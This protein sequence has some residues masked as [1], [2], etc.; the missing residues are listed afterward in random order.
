ME[1][2]GSFYG[3]FLFFYFVFSKKC[4]NFARKLKLMTMNKNYL[5]MICMAWLLCVTHATDAKSM[6]DFWIS[7]PDS[8]IPTMNANMRTELV[9]LQEMGVKSEVSNL[10]GDNVVLDTLTADFLQVRLSK[11]ATLQIKQ[12][13]LADGKDSLWC[14]VKTFSAPEKDSE[15]QFY[16]QQWQALDTKEY[17]GGKS[18][19]D[20]ME[21]LIQKPDTM[22]EARFEE[23]K[24][25]IEPRMMSAM[26]F[27]DDSSI[28]F[29]LSLPLMSVEDK[30][31]V[32]AIK[33][34]RKFNWNG[35]KFNEN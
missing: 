25:M 1:E 6:R 12:L 35:K 16:N 4:S 3:T 8:L 30:K 15:V 23:L 13:P 33:M 22:G 27:Q 28:V 34:Q 18:M 26:L 9:E 21:S 24:E 29:R 7:M 5:V 19:D 17:F 20:I 11:V 14:V 31:Q 10:L 32:K 2:E